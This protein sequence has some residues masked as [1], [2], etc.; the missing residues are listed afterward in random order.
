MIVK[1]ILAVS[2][3][4]IITACGFTNNVGVIG[5]NLTRLFSVHP[6]SV[7]EDGEEQVLKS[8]KGIVDLYFTEDICVLMKMEI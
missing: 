5:K 1:K 6:Y 8:G 3:L 2:L 7:K 4:L